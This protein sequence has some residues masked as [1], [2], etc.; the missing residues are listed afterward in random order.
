MYEILETKTFPDGSL[1][2]H[3]NRGKW[4]GDLF[5]KKMNNRNRIK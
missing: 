4:E 3:L 2:L 1:F 5:K